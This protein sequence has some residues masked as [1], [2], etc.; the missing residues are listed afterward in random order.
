MLLELGVE[1]IAIIERASLSLGPGFTA[2][3][4][5]TGAGKSLLSDSI[6]LALGDRADSSLVRTG[7][8]KGNV[9]LLADLAG[10]AP[11]LVR[12]AELGVDLEDG[13]LAVQRDVSQEGRST[14]RLNGRLVS[15]STL[16]EVGTLLADIHGQHDHQA[17]LA[18]ERQIE[19]LDEWIGE[20]ASQACAVVADS[21]LKAESLK[22]RLQALR[23][24]QRDREQR[25]DLLAFQVEEI[26]S[27]SPRPGESLELEASIER[28]RHAERLKQGTQAALGLLVTEEGSALDRTGQALKELEQLATLDP[29][30]EDVAKPVRD[31]L[32]YLQESGNGLSEYFDS[33][34]IDPAGLERAVE[35]MDAVKRLLRKYGDDES[36]VLDHC[37]AAKAELAEL[38]DTSVS[39]D[40][41]VR[42][43]DEAESSLAEAAVRLTAVRRAK[44]VEF[45][46]LVTAEVRELAMEKAEF[47]VAIEPKAVDASGADL[48][49]FLFTANPGEPLK[50]LIK[51]ASGG[52]ISRLMLAV[53]VAG[54]GRAGVPTLI[55]DEVDTGLSGKAAAVTAVKLS[56]LAEHYQVIVITH[57]PQIAAQADVQFHIEK[58]VEG[59]RTITNVHRLEGEGRVLEIARMLAGERVG[60]SAVANAAEL[61]ARRT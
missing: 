9:S 30:A 41:V 7:A 55:F 17:L 60:E 38:G 59:G 16:R 57:L 46:S 32:I 35:R 31:A 47:T 40:E 54:A 44:A 12:C 23:A 34:D 5:E 56:R 61:L 21:Y 24:G 26:E 11:A 29:G 45:A 49:T 28:M 3:T 8:S 50:P 4:G 10:N 27:V 48:V 58:R 13:R 19:F 14:V 36:A 22:R 43:L 42:Q 39:V 52:E 6:S 1:D 51:V 53:K 2:L 18:P 33:L 37:E 15:V 20:E 25:L